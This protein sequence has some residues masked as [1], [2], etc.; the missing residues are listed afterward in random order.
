VLK[1][2]ETMKVLGYAYATTLASPP[3]DVI[4]ARA[5]ELYFRRDVLVGH[6]F[7]SSFPGE[8]PGAGTR[9]PERSP[10]V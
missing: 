2:D 4:P 10:A 1:N 7:S 5:Q 3:G 6:D 9:K 8:C